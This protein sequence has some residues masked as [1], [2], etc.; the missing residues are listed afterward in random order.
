MTDTPGALTWARNWKA[1]TKAGARALELY[2][3]ATMKGIVKSLPEGVDQ[4]TA[5]GLVRQW[6]SQQPKLRDGL[7]R[8]SGATETAAHVRDGL[9][10]AVVKCREAAI[11]P[12]KLRKAAAALDKLPDIAK[13]CMAS[14]R[15]SD[16]GAS[17]DDWAAIDW[18]RKLG[19]ISSAPRRFREAAMALDRL[20]GM[21]VD[22][23]WHR[24]NQ[25]VRSA[26]RLAEE[27]AVLAEKAADKVRKVEGRPRP[28]W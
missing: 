15:S 14:L 7:R 23:D 10:A 8:T 24:R 19:D 16:A 27:L 22:D 25:Q 20:R 6:A 21:R 5:A 4:D 17:R 18:C 9:K 11:A 3:N 2:N 1:Q 13:G 26:Q 28:R 12:H